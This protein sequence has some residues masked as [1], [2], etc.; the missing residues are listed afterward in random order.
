MSYDEFKDLCRKSWEEEHNYLG[1][2]KSRKRDQGRCCA[3]NESKNTY[4]DCTFE[5]KTFWLT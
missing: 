2:N 1:F 3:C 4:T 5:T